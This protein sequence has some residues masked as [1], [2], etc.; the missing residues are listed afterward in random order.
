MAR[1][2][3]EN[4]VVAEAAAQ[5]E[6]KHQQIH[7]LQARLQKQLPALAARWNMHEFTAFQRDYSHFDSEF[8]RV[9]QGLDMIHASLTGQVEVPAS[10]GRIRQVEPRARRAKPEPPPL[11]STA[12]LPEGLA[13]LAE[14]NAELNTLLAALCD[15]VA[16]SIA[17]WSDASR[18]AWDAAQSSWDEANRRQ[19][20]IMDNLPQAM[21][22]SRSAQLWLPT[23]P[24]AS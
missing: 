24:V 22:K 6:V 13:R 4:P 21:R 10:A 5:I 14:A 19:Q 9:K 20:E 17:E 1:E 11:D 15:E 8:E 18:R 3:V 2:H 12:A 7:D 16:G 23:A